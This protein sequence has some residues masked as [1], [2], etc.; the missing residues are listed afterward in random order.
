MKEGKLIVLEGASD[1]IGKTTQHNLLKKKLEESGQKITSHHFPSYQTYQAAP[2]EKYL[3]GQY[4]K[5]TELSPYFIN[6]LYA[7]DRGI[8]WIEELKP[9]YEQGNIILLDRYTTSSLIYQTALIED[10]KERKKIIDYIID[11]E[12]NKIGIKE[13]D[14]VVF[15]TAP[16]DLITKLRTERKQKYGEIIKNDIHENNINHMKKVY[17]NALFLADYLSW[18]KVECNTGNKM[19]SIEEINEELYRLVAT[20][21]NKRQ[22]INIPITNKAKKLTKNRK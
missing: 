12:Y 14:K 17:E 2:V 5:I 8:T 18:K 9:A 15:L 4:G 6:S 20:E 3:S 16:F 7:L 22:Y 21:D 10:I 1:G 13:P 19:K 11:F